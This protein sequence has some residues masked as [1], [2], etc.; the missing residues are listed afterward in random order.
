MRVLGI[1]QALVLGFSIYYSLLSTSTT[2]QHNT[3][4]A[5]RN[6]KQYI[7]KTNIALFQSGGSSHLTAAVMSDQDHLSSVDRGRSQV[8]HR[9]DS[10]RHDLSAQQPGRRTGSPDAMYSALCRSGSAASSSSR[11]LDRACPDTGSFDGGQ[12]TEADGFLPVQSKDST[13]LSGGAQ[14]TVMCDCSP[15]SLLWRTVRQR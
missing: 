10:E 8:T 5:K 2:R 15:S 12:S 1:V 7:A 9:W 4:Q 13:C 14:A 11:G 6:I 3:I